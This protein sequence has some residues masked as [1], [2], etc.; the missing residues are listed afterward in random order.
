MN[1]VLR[2]GLAQGRCAFP[3]E[4]NRALVH[5][6]TN[7][8]WFHSIIFLPKSQAM[9]AENCLH[10]TMVAASNAVSH[11]AS[12]CPVAREKLLA[13]YVSLIKAAGLCWEKQCARW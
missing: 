10:G 5:R 4:K 6:S 3:S 12:V 1:C 8:W 2:H 7:T 11:L 13:R 9:L